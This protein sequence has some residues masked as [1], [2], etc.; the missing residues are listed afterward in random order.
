[1]N[2]E[3]IERAGREVIEGLLKW[4]HADRTPINLLAAIT[5]EVGEVAHA[6]NHG[7]GQEATRQEIVEVIALLNRLYEMV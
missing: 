6:I 5:E 4:G 3:L 7:E 1:M 2:K